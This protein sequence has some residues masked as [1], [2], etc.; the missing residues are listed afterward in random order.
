MVSYGFELVIPHA[1]TQRSTH[2]ASV[3]NDEV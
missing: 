2:W 1:K 3:E